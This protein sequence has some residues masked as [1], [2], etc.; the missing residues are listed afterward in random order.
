MAA[1]IATRWIR[2]LAG[3]LL[4]AVFLELLLGMRLV[5][6]EIAFQLATHGQT[7]WA[8]VIYAQLANEGDAI[9][10]NNW[11]VIVDDNRYNAATPEERRAWRRR[12]YG[13]YTQAAN[14]GLEAAKLNLG[15][16]VRNQGRK[17][18]ALDRRWFQLMAE[19]GDTLAKLVY[20]R[21]YPRDIHGQEYRDRIAL[22]KSLADAG[23]ADAQYWYAESLEFSDR[24]T[25]REYYRRAAEQGHV[26][27]I[28]DYASWL[29]GHADSAEVV[30]WARLGAGRGNLL[31]RYLMADFY[32]RGDLL[33]R[34]DEKAA[35][36]YRL[37]VDEENVHPKFI[38][39]RQMER[40]GFRCC[41]WTDQEYSFDQVKSSAA[42]QLALLYLAGTGVPRDDSKARFYL[43]TA[44]KTCWADIC[45]EVKKLLAL[46]K[47]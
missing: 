16:M 36:W 17:A 18:S 21:N 23:F 37:A 15:Q 7:D 4:L 22:L 43:E 19:R 9:G 47:P 11:A 46:M 12:V 28:G 34:D 2:W 8:R 10:L 3:L 27:A 20:A 32:H 13:A 39:L 42:Y 14:L 41:L 31:S 45:D 5:R 6:R 38:R 33:P 25:M 29:R 35:Y 30:K 44:A 1:L 24:E 26:F 40:S